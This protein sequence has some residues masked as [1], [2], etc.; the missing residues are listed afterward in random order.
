MNGIFVVQIN[1]GGRIV[2][3]Y[4][5]QLIAGF[6][7]LVGST[8]FAWYEGSGI[9]ENSWEWKYSTP[10]SKLFNIEIINGR[11]ISQLDYFVYAAKFQPFF[12][13]IMIISGLYIVSV[14]IIYLLKHNR[15]LAMVFS[16]M[17][18]GI[19]IVISS[20]LLHTS[21]NGGKV[22]FGVSVMG[23]LF[24]ICMAVSSRFVNKAEKKIVL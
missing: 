20:L 2:F 1:K 22:L 24:F 13:T 12:P 23:A 14:M 21:T 9:I 7:T 3:K 10:F 4:V 15:Q 17:T 11:E 6:L 19:L 8:F 16:G 18:S 5:V